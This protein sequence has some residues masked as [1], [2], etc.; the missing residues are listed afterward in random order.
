MYAVEANYFYKTYIT[1]F[2]HISEKDVNGDIYHFVTIH[3]AALGQQNFFSDYIT[4]SAMIDVIGECWCAKRRGGKIKK[5]HVKA[6][7]VN[8]S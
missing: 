3:W 5:T 8:C 4:I 6:S 1:L 2:N 7:S